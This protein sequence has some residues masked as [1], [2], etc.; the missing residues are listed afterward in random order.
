MAGVKHCIAMC[1]GTTALEI[2]IRAAGLGGEVIVPAFTFVATAH[3]LQ[4]QAITPVFCDIRPDD[5]NI[6]PEKV[7]ELITART[8][9]IIGVHLWGRPCDVEALTE[10]AA[11]HRIALLFDA[12]QAFSCSRQGRPVGGFGDAEVFSFHATK[13]LNTFE[14]GAVATNDDALA[15]RMRLMRNFGF[16]GYDRV[17]HIGTNGKMAEVSAAMGLTS[18]ESIDEFVAVNRRNYRQYRDA[19]AGLVGVKLLQYD[20]REKN[21]YQY[22]VVEIDRLRCGVSRDRLLEIL[23]SE[24]ILA[25]R[26]FFPGCHLMEPYRSMY[27]SRKS[28]L[29]VTD[30]I[31]GRVLSLPT[32]TAVGDAEIATICSIVRLALE[33][34]RS[35][36]GGLG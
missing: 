4:W 28:R 5:H 8:T 18:L 2:A 25:R 17:V 12:A 27:P 19:L 34:E 36:S 24:N 32:G 20:D 3:A 1:N 16:S 6:D 22:V 11:R 26:Y 33:H 13:F 30:R 21:N 29:A 15:A 35:A 31:A 10:I 7:E 23:H 14:G 9:G